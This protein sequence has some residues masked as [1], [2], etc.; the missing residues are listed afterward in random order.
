MVFCLSDS[1]SFCFLINSPW[2]SAIF[3]HIIFNLNLYLVLLFVELCFHLSNLYRGSSMLGL[4]LFFFFMISILLAGNKVQSQQPHGF[5]I[6]CDH[7][8]LSLATSHLRSVEQERKRSK[9][10]LVCVLSL[11]LQF[12]IWTWR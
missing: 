4:C 6:S 3:F 12:N 10:R 2:L 5:S 7:F 1:D 11:F 8:S 9:L